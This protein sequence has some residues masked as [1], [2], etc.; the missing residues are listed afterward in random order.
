MSQSYNSTVAEFRV[1]GNPIKHSQ[2]PVI[3]RAFA[4][5]TG[6]QLNYTAQQVN[7]VDFETVV[8]DFFAAGGKGLNITAP[9]KQHAHNMSLHVQPA[10]YFAGAANTLWQKNGQLVA[11]NTDG[12]GLV[13][14]ICQNLGGVLK[15]SRILMLGAG[16][17]VRGVLQSLLQQKP[18]QLVI[19]NRTHQK[20]QQLAYKFAKLGPVTACKLDCLKTPFDWII[21]ATTAS[22][23]GKLP[24]IPQALIN[25]Q[26]HCYDMMYGTGTTVFNRWALKWGAATTTDGLGML[27][28]QAA[29]AFYLWYC[30]QPETSQ[31]LL[32]LR[33]QL[34]S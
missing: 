13:R 22:L 23:M 33:L 2:S 28:E 6:K 14:D 8:N 27:V 34:G 32:D 29:A 17:A 21:N 11:D 1:L 16:G 30:I 3:H 5:A 24:D 19:A 4:V 20:A 18:A 10:A 9:F 31:V 15:G 7:E 12:I 26:T 25:H